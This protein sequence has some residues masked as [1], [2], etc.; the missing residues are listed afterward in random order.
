MRRQPTRRPWRGMWSL[1]LAAT[2]SL[3][4]AGLVPA[5]SAAAPADRATAFAAADPDAQVHGLKGEYYRMSAPG[6]R[7]FAELG[8]TA[9]DPASI[10]PAW[11]ARSRR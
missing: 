2:L 7:D 10:F 11:P 3:P 8:G 4:V 1:L 9:L 5:A 6:A